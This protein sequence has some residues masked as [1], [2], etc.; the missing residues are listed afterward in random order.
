MS[1]DRALKLVFEEEGGYVDHPDDPGGPT[2]LG[3]TQATLTVARRRHPDLRLPERVGSLTRAQAREIYLRDYWR[4]SHCEDMPAPVAL[5]VFDMAINHGTG[6]AIRILQRSLRVKDDGAFGPKSRA[7]LDDAMLNGL[8][9][10]MAAQRQVFYA[11][12]PTF[13]TFGLGWARR[14][15]RINWEAGRWLT[16]Q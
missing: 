7:A 14:M 9:I 15:Q 16:H 6:A 8:L 1:F 13:A 10:E 5:V 4:P 3:V 11:A 2:N 12:L